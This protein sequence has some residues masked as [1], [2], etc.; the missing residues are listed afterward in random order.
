MSGLERHRFTGWIAGAG[1][2][3]G[4]RLVLGLW[5][6]SPWGSFADVMVEHPDGHRVL[7]APDQR[8]V[9][10][11]AATYVFDELRLGGLRARTSARSV[12]VEGP[13]LAVELTVGERTPLGWLLST[14]PT[15]LATA[16]WWLRAI[17]PVARVVMPGVGTAGSA[18]SG[19]T[20]YYGATDVHRV[21]GLSGEVDGVDLGALRPVDPPVRFGFSSTPRTPSLVAVT[22]TIDVPAG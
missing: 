15:G 11:V 5:R 19:R 8:V 18:G 21:V 16:P 1:S 9:D 2:A 17:D 22:T 12:T 4:P 20:E 10:Y 14:V 13:R 6:D 3:A 7:H